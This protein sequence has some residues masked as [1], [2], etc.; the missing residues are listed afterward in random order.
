[1]RHSARFV[2]SEQGQL[3]EPNDHASLSGE[4]YKSPPALQAIERN[5]HRTPVTMVVFPETQTLLG[6]LSSET[7]TLP[8][9]VPSISTHF[10]PPVWPR[11]QTAEAIIS[12]EYEHTVPPFALSLSDAHNAK[13][14]P[15][16]DGNMYDNQGAFRARVLEPSVVSPIQRQTSQLACTPVLV[17]I[18]PPRND[19][20]GVLAWLRGE[21]EYPAAYLTQ[22]MQLAR[23][24]QRQLARR[25]IARSRQYAEDEQISRILVKRL[26]RMIMR[27]GRHRRRPDP[28]DWLL[29]LAVLSKA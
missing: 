24:T 28:G 19:P 23:Q 11:T 5:L 12:G 8:M 18:P 27:A 15:T 3:D 25:A 7:S 14:N 13:S 26:K 22:S 10:P 4:W 1:M 20:R 2:K 9:S 16:A 29:L 6:H 21:C 17:E